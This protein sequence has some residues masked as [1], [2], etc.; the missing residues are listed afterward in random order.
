[1]KPIIKI[2]NKKNLSKYGYKYLKMEQYM[3]TYVYVYALVDKNA[4]PL[5]KD[6]EVLTNNQIFM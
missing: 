5:P 1:M 2:L 4:L 3:D 6:I